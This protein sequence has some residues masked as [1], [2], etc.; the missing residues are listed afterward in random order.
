[1]KLRYLFVILLITSFLLPQQSSQAQSTA[2]TI[3]AV[4]AI[5]IDSENGQVLMS[6]NADEILQVGSI[7]KLLSVYV[8]LKTIEAQDE[9]TR[10]SIVPISDEAYQLSQD[11]NIGNVPLRQDY[12]YTVNELVEAVSINLANGATL[13]LAEMVGET[14]ADFV[15]MMETQL[16]EWGVE[17]FNLINSTGLED[18]GETN[19]FSAEVA[20]IIAYHLVNDFPDYLDYSDQAK[21]VFK[22]N[23]D[24]AIDMNNYNQ[25]LKGKPYER[26]NVLGLMPGSSE[27]DGNSFVGYSNEDEFG[28]ITVVLGTEDEDTRYEETDRLMDYSYSAYMKELVVSEGQPTTQV[29]TIKVEGS[30]ESEAELI[31]GENM[32]LVVPIIDTAPRLE[33]EFSSNDALFED[34]SYLVAPVEQGEVVGE[35]TIYGADTE[36]TYL[37]STKGNHVPVVQAEPIEE[38]AWYVNGWHSFSNG[39]SNTWESTRRFFVDLFN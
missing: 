3:D 8:A 30:S 37:P 10:E 23:T 27:Q 15:K 35:M 20:A 36:F 14:E 38:A 17:E 29:N 21:A 34:R 28:I 2:P 5:S 16:L 24:D 26:E 7:S 13:A 19:T 18:N 32:S 22:P 25:M 4:S 9:W 6:Q 33:Y 31:Y 39:V 11:Y 1:M 12:N